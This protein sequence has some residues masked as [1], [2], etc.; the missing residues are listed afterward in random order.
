M[1]SW[2]KSQAYLTDINQVPVTEYRTIIQESP[3]TFLP[4]HLQ[5]WLG[6]LRLFYGIPF[7]YLVPDERLLPPES[8][9]FFY[10]DRNWND[11]MVDGAL[12]VGKTATREYTHHH[13]LFQSVA[14]E[15]DNEERRIRQNLRL[16]DKSAEEEDLPGIGEAADMTGFLLRSQAVSFYPGLEVK[17]WQGEQDNQTDLRLLRMDRP[18]PD[19]LLCLF[20][21][22]PDGVDIKE[23]REG[24]QFGVDINLDAN[25]NIEGT[26]DCP[27]GFSLK[28]RHIKGTN[29]GYEVGWVNMDISDDPIDGINQSYDVSVP[30]RQDNPQVV[31]VEAL[32]AAVADKMSEIKA[33]HGD[34]FEYEGST[35]PAELA[36]QM[37]Q[38]PFQQR[39]Y[40]DGQPRPNDPMP[41]F[42]LQTVYTSATV[43]AVVGEIQALSQEER[44]ALLQENAGE[45]DEQ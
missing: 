13:A 2:Y 29:A 30:V 20:D 26:A 32:H 27:G 19:V 42:H 22:V 7:E 24:I 6:R 43:G 18:G 17:A 40:G 12:S 3:E 4:K 41:E 38:F 10:V 33:A 15:L 36:V 44:D 16:K 1:K 8:I 11:R 9:R 21:G 37:L 35:G 39:F 5:D 23:P 31:H 25:Q 28:M 14:G 34:N 45:E